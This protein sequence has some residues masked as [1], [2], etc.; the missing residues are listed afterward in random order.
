MKILLSLNL[1]IQSLEQPV[2]VKAL[3]NHVIHS[4]STQTNPIH[5][6][7]DNHHEDI[8]FYIIKSPQLPLELH[9]LRSIILI[10]TGSQVKSLD[11]EPLV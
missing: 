10:F 6:S 1:Q 7:L 3:D 4:F 11:G 8:Q 5:V 2:Q 9:G